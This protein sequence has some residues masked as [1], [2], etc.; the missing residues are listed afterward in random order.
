MTATA[1]NAK[2]ERLKTSQW[3]CWSIM[4]TAKIIIS[5][6]CDACITCW[7]ETCTISCL[8]W[9]YNY[10][11]LIQATDA[12]PYL[13]I[14]VYFMRAI[15]IGTKLYFSRLH[16]FSLSCLFSKSYDTEYI[17]NISKRKN[18][19]APHVANYSKQ[20]LKIIRLSYLSL[21]SCHTMSLWS[22]SMCHY[23]M[24]RGTWYPHT[25]SCQ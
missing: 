14:T 24:L 4:I 15:N 11:D 22:W 3:K 10:I 23:S 25:S 7:K 5:V 19:I 13:D 8:T 1:S 16:F 18:K 12:K 21:Y 17:I 9:T 2:K 6:N 20:H